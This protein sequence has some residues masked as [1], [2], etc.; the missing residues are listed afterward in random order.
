[1]AEAN[2]SVHQ[3]QLPGMIQLQT[4]NA[5]AIRQNR[6]FSQLA[7]LPAIDERLRS[8]NAGYL[9]DLLRQEFQNK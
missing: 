4:G 3:R 8:R 2:Q 6:G 7:H 9:R 5:F 1:M